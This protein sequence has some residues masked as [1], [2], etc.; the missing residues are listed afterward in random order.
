MKLRFPSLPRIGL[1]LAATLALAACGQESAPIGAPAPAATP[2]PAGAPAGNNG[3]AAPATRQPAPAPE[4]TPGPVV[5]PQGPAPVAGTDY[6]EIA[7]GQP[8]TPGNTK[9]EVV[10]A[11]GYTCPACAQFEPLLSAWAA[12]QPADVEL[13]PVPAP[14]GGFWMPYAKAYYA[15]ES[16]GIAERS[17]EAMFEAF[18]VRRE[19]DHES[20]ESQIAQF[21]RQFDVDPQAFARTMSS[22][23][24]N[25]KV[26]RARQFLQRTGVDATPTLVI[27]GRYR[28]VGG[29]SWEEKL[30]IADHLVAM[31]R[32]ARGGAGDAGSDAVPAGNTDTDAADTDAAVTDAG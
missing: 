11:F 9:I 14:F 24:V 25:A 13:I 12:R 6:V 7:S 26:N 3:P 30:R 29:D 28:V 32:D 22:F 27:D 23:A 4:R 15:A 10:E 2:T 5:P 20:S 21:Y 18:H 1:V 17:H 16:A 31:R 19:L 8:F